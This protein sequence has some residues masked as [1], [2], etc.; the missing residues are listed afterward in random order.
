M[1]NRLVPIARNLRGSTSDAELKH[2]VRCCFDDFFKRKLELL[3]TFDLRKSLRTLNPCILKKSASGLASEV[4]VGLLKAHTNAQDETIFREVFSEPI[5]HV[6]SQ[7]KASFD[8]LIRAI[9][10]EPT[11]YEDEYDDSWVRAV[12]SLTT[13]FID[14]FCLD[15]AIDWEKLARLYQKESSDSI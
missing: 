11:K 15:G 6:T 7:G 8:K 4:V 10:V 1:V 2:L 13:Q 12:N 3:R 14:D 5:A 9:N